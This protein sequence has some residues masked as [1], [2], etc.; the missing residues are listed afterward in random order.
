MVNDTI[1]DMLTRIRNA[2]LA[3]KKTVSVSKTKIHEK[4]CDILEKE[5]FIASFQNS[6]N[7]INELEFRIKQLELHIH[8]RKYVEGMG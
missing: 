3:H 8:K 6:E 4:I 1:S 5:G 2:N 7:K